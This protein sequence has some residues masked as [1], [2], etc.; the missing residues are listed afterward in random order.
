MVLVE[1]EGS[2]R[3]ES[4]RFGPLSCSFG[5]FWFLFGGLFRGLSRVNPFGA[6]IGLWIRSEVGMF[7]LP[8]R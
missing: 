7:W 3:L 8:P 1:A 2:C 5:L 6:G 4:F